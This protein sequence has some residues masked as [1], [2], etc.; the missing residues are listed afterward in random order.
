LKKTQNFTKEPRIKIRNK[1]KGIDV[2]IPVNKRTILELFIYSSFFKIMR[3]KSGRGRNK[4][5]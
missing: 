3:E 4:G 1:K 2:D 5:N